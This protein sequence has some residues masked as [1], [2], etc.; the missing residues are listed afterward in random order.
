[1]K[2]LLDTH[3]LIWLLDYPEELREEAR[4]AIADRKN[5]VFVSVVSVW[6]AAIKAQ[7]GKLVM[8]SNFLSAI[9]ESGLQILTI[10]EEHALRAASLPMHHRDPF[11]RMLIAQAFIEELTLVTRDS[12]IPA[13]G[14]PILLS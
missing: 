9:R 4:S 10:T 11:D 3:S 2:L 14:I 1:M 12:K 5:D 8:P 7:A 13:Y 6:E